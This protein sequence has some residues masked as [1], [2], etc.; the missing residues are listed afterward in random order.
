[1][2]CETVRC[3]E[4][5]RLDTNLHCAVADRRGVTRKGLG[6]PD[7][8]FPVLL[9]LRQNFPSRPRKGRASSMQSMRD[10]NKKSELI[11]YKKDLKFLIGDGHDKGPLLPPTLSLCPP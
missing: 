9:P 10:G 7:C 11:W 2:F 5:V 6:S 3:A 4:P 8:K 1:M